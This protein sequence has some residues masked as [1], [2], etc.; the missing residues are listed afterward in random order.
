MVVREGLVGGSWCVGCGG[1]VALGVVEGVV[2][3]GGGGVGVFVRGSGFSACGYGPGAY[4]AFLVF[5]GVFDEVCEGFDGLL[6]GSLREVVFGEADATGSGGCLCLLASGAGAGAGAAGGVGGLLDE[7]VFTQAGLFA[8]EV[9]LFRLLE[10]LGVRAD[11]LLGHSI[12]E[13]AAACVAGVFSLE[14]ACVLVAARGR[15]MGALPAGGA[16]VAVAASEG[17]VLGSLEGFRGG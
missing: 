3:G 10:G 4:E 1:V 7:T 15:L 2:E 13:L 14:D 17:E 11:Y 6:G 8:L 9:A 16:M 12:G 5:R